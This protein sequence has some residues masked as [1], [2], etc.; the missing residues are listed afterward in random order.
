M[1]ALLSHSRAGHLMTLPQKSPSAVRTL[2]PAAEATGPAESRVAGPDAQSSDVPTWGWAVVEI[3]RDGTC[4]S[5][6]VVPAGP[7]EVTAKAVVAAVTAPQSREL[8]PA[9]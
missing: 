4:G 6:R 2:V 9:L 8:G 3:R 7:V 1:A 5:P